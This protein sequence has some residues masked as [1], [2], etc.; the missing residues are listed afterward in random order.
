MSE[1]K[2]SAS[3]LLQTQE[4]HKRGRLK[5]FLG[6]APG[7]GKTYAMLT[8]AHELRDKGLD[9]IIG[10]VDTHGRADTANLVEGLELIERKKIIYEGRSFE[11]LDVKAIIQR[12]PAIV[13]V[14]EMP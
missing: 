10:L 4:M 7:V 2:T 8:E 5:I 14:D 12:H 6:M 13:I 1:T 3:A 9:V 11:E